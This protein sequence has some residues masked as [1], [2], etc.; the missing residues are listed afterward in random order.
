MKRPTNRRAERGDL[1]NR[2]SQHRREKTTVLIVCEGR[3][4]ERNYLEELKREDAV[5]S[6]F[7]IKVVRGSG[8]SRQQ[9]VQRAADFK[10][11]PQDDFDQVWCIMDTERLDHDDA[12]QDFR[13][14]MKLAVEHGIKMVLSN[15]AF[16][17][18]L[19]AHFVRTSR[20]FKDCDAVIV[21]LNKHWRDSFRRDYTKSD[22]RMYGLLS[23]WMTVGIKNARAVREQDH[24]NK[25][26]MADCN[27]ATEV[28]Q[29]VEYFF[30]LAAPAWAS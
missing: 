22:P 3:E 9:I 30:S 18:W 1:P 29:L 12:R 13:Q 24:L 16:E 11:R 23:K 27:S 2:S 10:N 21:E 15:P 5:S 19:L 25:P 26:D 8:G 20:S 14:A 7:S 4:T 6:G 17:V 28:Y